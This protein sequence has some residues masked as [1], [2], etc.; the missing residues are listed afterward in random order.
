MEQSVRDVLENPFPASEIRTRKGTFGKELAYAEVHN[1]IARLNQA[2]A[3]DW[4]FDIIEHSILDAEVIVLGK[5]AAGDVHKTAFGSSAITTT[6]DSG[7]K[8]SIGDD[9]KAA[10][11]DSLKKC[12]SLLGVGLELYSGSS[13]QSATT[14]AAT[15]AP[16]SSRNARNGGDEGRGQGPTISNG[17]RI[18]E[19]QLQAVLSLA[20]SRGGGAVA[21]RTQILDR[22]GLPLE[23]LDRRQA[24]QIISALN[25]GGLAVGGG[26]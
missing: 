22:F 26:S 14:K 24:S 2:F 16:R 21:V 1:Y 18:T 15:K 11:S 25:N 4:S 3:G 6:R 7:E 12:S 10:A 19:R 5:L 17:A 13:G 23:K 20:E 8:V 9:L